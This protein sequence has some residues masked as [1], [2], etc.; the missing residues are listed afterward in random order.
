M[1]HGSISEQTRLNYVSLCY[2]R[3]WIVFIALRSSARIQRLFARVE[4]A[5]R[6]VSEPRTA[7][8]LLDLWRTI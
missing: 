6:G 1:P 3:V 7:L 2:I 8:H 4:R 5:L